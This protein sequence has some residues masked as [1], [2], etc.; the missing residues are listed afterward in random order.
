MRILQLSLWFQC[1]GLISLTK[2]GLSMVIEHSYVAAVTNLISC[3]TRWPLRCAVH[4]PLSTAALAVKLRFNSRHG[5][6]LRRP[7]HQDCV[8]KHRLRPRVQHMCCPHSLSRSLECSPT[9][10]CLCALNHT[11]HQVLRVNGATHPP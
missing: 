4:E 6:D 11:V 7:H 8:S 10:G 9:G 1:Q 2:T 3:N 5:D